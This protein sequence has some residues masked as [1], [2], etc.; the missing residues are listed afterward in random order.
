MTPAATLVRARPAVFS[1]WPPRL[2]LLAG[3]AL[4]LSALVPPDAQCLGAL[5]AVIVLG[6]PHG[7]LDGEIARSL[8]RPRFGWA[9]FPIFSL[10][11]LVLFALVLVAW[12]LA[13]VPTLAAFL[14]A[15]VWHF[16]LEDAP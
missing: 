4:A 12:H 3:P 7:A 13:P 15:S 10:P 9:W 1:P 6:V 5:L 2:V 11:Y 16:G 8:L 14:A